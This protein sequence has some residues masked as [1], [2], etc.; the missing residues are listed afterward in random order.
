MRRQE[1]MLSPYPI[2][3][4]KLNNMNSSSK[5]L[6]RKEQAHM[7][8]VV[9]QQLDRMSAVEGQLMEIIEGLEVMNSEF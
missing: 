3:S 8:N 9:Q 7:R 2:S 5:N 6:V 4:R 1:V